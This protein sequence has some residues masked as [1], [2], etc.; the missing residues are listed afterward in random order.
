M[1]NN[2][3]AS[4]SMSTVRKLN[5]R[6]VETFTVSQ[7]QID[8]FHKCLVKAIVTGNV[9]FS[10]IEN[11]H[12]NEGMRAIGIPGMTR[13]QLSNKHIPALAA[14]AVVTN[15]TMLQKA[16]LV[17]ASSDGWRKKYCEQ[18][19]ALNNVVALLLDRAYVHDAVNCSTMRMNAAAVAAFLEKSA[20]SLV[21]PSDVELER[22]VGGLS[23][24]QKPTGVPC[25]TC[26]R[27]TPSGSCVAASLMV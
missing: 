21:G 9:P 2:A 17:D 23:T 7:S 13:K 3:A 4:T 18:S 26:R 27:C 1:S 5:Q 19:G 24:T 15:A 12:L 22:L 11:A 20:A 6:G 16:L 25:W 10:W 14:E 8:H